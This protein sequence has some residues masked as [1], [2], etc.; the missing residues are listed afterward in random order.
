MTKIKGTTVTD[1]SPWAYFYKYL[2]RI[3]PDKH[4][5]LQAV[6]ATLHLPD[7]QLVLLSS[8]REIGRHGAPLNGTTIEAV[9]IDAL[10]QM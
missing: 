6:L 7:L 10:T 5:A 4:S 8:G 1:A 3:A 9:A 2:L